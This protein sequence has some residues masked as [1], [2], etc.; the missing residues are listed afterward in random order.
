MD[1][2]SVIL[3]RWMVVVGVLP[4]EVPTILPV[5]IKP[6][7][8]WSV[9]RDPPGGK[10]YTALKESSTITTSMAIANM[11]AADLATDW[12]FKGG[13]GFSGEIDGTI[14]PFG[15]GLE[16]K[17][18]GVDL[19]HTHSMK[20]SGPDASITKKSKTHF[21]V[22]FFESL[23][24]SRE[25]LEQVKFD[26]ETTIETSREPEFAGQPSVSYPTTASLTCVGTGLDPGRRRGFASHGR[27][28]GW[29]HD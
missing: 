8:I 24:L 22:S 19:K 28:Q 16:A 17:V 11:H 18:G 25:T 3:E 15:F 26:F 4:K 2:S 5:S 14:A 29:A 10:S 12:G 6:T 20:G 9:I 1:Q 7:L 23:S 27:H 21:E 13:L